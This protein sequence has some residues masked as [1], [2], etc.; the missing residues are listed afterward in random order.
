MQK[1]SSPKSKKVHESIDA[2]LSAKRSN[3]VVSP[4]AVI[5]LDPEDP[6]RPKGMHEVEV[7]AYEDLQALGLVHPTLRE[8]IA[9][10]AITADDSSAW[11][12]IHKSAARQEEGC[13]C[14]CNPNSSGTEASVSYLREA[15][16]RF[17]QTRA[18]MHGQL[19]A[20][21]SEAT[22]RSSKQTDLDV[23]ST[24]WW[25]SILTK[26]GVFKLF[27]WLLN[28]VEI[29]KNSQLV[30]AKS[31]KGLYGNALKIHKG[32]ELIIKGSGV[33]LRFA[34]AQGNLS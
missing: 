8:D 16:A 13:G 1:Q 3:L 12:V 10:K 17:S 32:G 6:R 28:D 18:T 34:S 24:Y 22:G 2:F 31:T 25:T 30:L 9:R 26:Y 33:K 7:H 11:E 23:S 4:G 21:I 5:V 15:R 14:R 20:A 27:L 19:A 29:M